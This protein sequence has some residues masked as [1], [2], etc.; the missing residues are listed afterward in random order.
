[1]KN[2]IYT[3]LQKTAEDRSVWQTLRKNCHKASE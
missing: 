2:S 3:N 1:M